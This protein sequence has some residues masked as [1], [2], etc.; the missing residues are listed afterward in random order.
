MKNIRQLVKQR[1]EQFAAMDSSTGDGP[2]RPSAQAM[3]SA[4]SGESVGCS[5][6][7]TSQTSPLVPAVKIGGDAG[8]TV[9]L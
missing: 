5:M 6:A 7:G 9:V 8:A 3:G 4:H 1:C 2:T